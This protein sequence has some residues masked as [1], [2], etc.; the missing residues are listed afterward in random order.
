MRKQPCRW[1]VASGWITP[2]LVFLGPILLGGSR[3]SA[4]VFRYKDGRTISGTVKSQTEKQINQRPVTIWT[5]EI[6]PQTY[7]QVLESELQRNGHDQP[8]ESELEYRNKV[9]SLPQTA[10]AHCAL[11]AWCTQQGMMDLAEAHYRR[12]LDLDPDHEV[13]RASTDFKKDDNGRWVRKEEI[14][15]EQRGKVYYK[16]RW[17]FP[18]SVAIEQ[19]QEKAEQEIAPLKKDLSRWHTAASFGRSPKLRKEGLVNLEQVQDPKAIGIL[20]GYLLETRKRPP[21]NV[22]LTYVRVLGRFKHIGASQA[23]STAAITDPDEQVRQASM[24]ALREFGGEQAVPKFISYLAN[25]QNELVNR[26]AIALGYFDPP[27]AVLP[28]IEALVTKH[29]QI[30]NSGPQMNAS[31]QGAFSIGGGPKKTMVPMENSHVLGTLSQ[32]TGKN[33]E[34][35]KPQWLA[36]YA[37]VYAAPAADL[38]RDP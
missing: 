29:L 15:G 28:L 26:A 1:M 24:N 32:I 9:G 16:G 35:N 36:W 33:F 21:V 30:A 37:S 12:A 27:Q 6:A 19:A 38:R 3:L 18:E 34:Y 5:V 23:L 4:D 14:Y 20:S 10:E 11:A 17:R 7:V 8:S 22:R 2:A 13:A 25:D 31:T